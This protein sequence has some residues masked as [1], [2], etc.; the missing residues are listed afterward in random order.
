MAT[1]PFTKA[2]QAKINTA[3]ASITEV[4]ADI[5]KAKSAGVDVSDAEKKL[6]D[7]ETRL[8]NIKNVY[9]PAR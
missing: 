6:L 2:D 5:A 1:N 3:L 7:A 8:R 9:F 4:K